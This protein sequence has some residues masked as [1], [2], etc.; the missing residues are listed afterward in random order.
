MDR[1]Q[2][3]TSTIGNAMAAAIAGSV[4]HT[5]GLTE[6]ADAAAATMARGETVG[7]FDWLYEN[8][9]RHHPEMD[10][11]DGDGLALLDNGEHFIYVAGLVG[12]LT[13]AKSMG[14]EFDWV[15]EDRDGTSTFWRC[16]LLDGD[17]YL[18][19]LRYRHFPAGFTPTAGCREGLRWEGGLAIQ[20]M[21]RYV[22]LSNWC[23]DIDPNEHEELTDSQ[24][25][26]LLKVWD[27]ES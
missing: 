23:E 27:G 9:S 15:P 25:Q 22:G 2:F 11:D 19:C 7:V 17:H 13:W 26:H 18:H 5:F 20:E 16:Y 8:L 24:I 21:F 3:F 10:P 4:P 14:Y 1:R 12:G 6:S